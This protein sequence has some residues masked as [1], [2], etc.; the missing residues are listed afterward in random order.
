MAGVAKGGRPWA[1]P[2]S[3]PASPAAAAAAA[4]GGAVRETGPE[5]E[6]AEGGGALYLCCN[7]RVL[8]LK[9]EAAEEAAEEGGGDRQAW[10]ALKARLRSFA[11]GRDV[12]VVWCRE[13]YDPRYGVESSVGS[14]SDEYRAVV[15][16]A[17]K[18]SPL[19]QL[20]QVVARRR[21][22]ELD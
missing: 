20:L 13:N 21:T 18:K 17:L 6:E 12:E 4:V 5:E 14:M 16:D 7:G 15:E 3:T 22:P 11:F 9:S 10:H 2:T 1:W 19:G 8:A